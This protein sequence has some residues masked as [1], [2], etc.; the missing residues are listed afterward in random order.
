MSESANPTWIVTAAGIGLA[1]A[2]GRWDARRTAKKEQR[3][4]L[5]R[6]IAD[7]EAR[8]LKL[9]AERDN[10]LD[11]LAAMTRALRDAERINALLTAAQG[12]TGGTV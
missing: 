2:G 10:A 9:E 8:V 4:E 7:L 6:Q 11:R 12:Q 1:F 3:D 5:R